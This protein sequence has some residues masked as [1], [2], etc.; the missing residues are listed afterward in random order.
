[1]AGQNYDITAIG[2]T[3]TF[4]HPLFE[5]GVV[6]SDASDD[7]EFIAVSRPKFGATSVGLNLDQINH[8]VPSIYQLTISVIPNGN[9]DRILQKI[10]SYSRPQ[11]EVVNIDFPNAV[12]TEPSGNKVIFPNLNMEEGEISNSTAINGR[13]KTKTYVWG[14]A[15][16][17]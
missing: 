6:L 12:V 7:V 15:T 2:T 8:K 13:F 5:G 9:S 14:G 11:G 17:I 10:T 16:V 3:V 4:M 1:M